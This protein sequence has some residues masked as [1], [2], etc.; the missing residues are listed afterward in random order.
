MTEEFRYGH[1]VIFTMPVDTK[2]WDVHLPNVQSRQSAVDALA[3]VA[4]EHGIKL[5]GSALIH[6]HEFNWNLIS[7]GKS[8]LVM[9]GL[10]DHEY[11]RVTDLLPPKFNLKNVHV[12]KDSMTADS[13]LNI[14]SPKDM[15]QGNMPLKS[16]ITVAQF[17]DRAVGSLGSRE[18]NIDITPAF[19]MLYFSATR[20]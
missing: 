9:V 15:M 2:S 13:L 8:K 7:K 1:A 17:A 16:L 6:P 11:P 12:L 20:R 5:V 3:K 10:S 4:H 14:P 18:I 19:N